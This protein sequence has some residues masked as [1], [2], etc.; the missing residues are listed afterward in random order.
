[1]KLKC[2]N[3]NALVSAIITLA[4]S[5]SMILVFFLVFG[6]FDLTINTYGFV[7]LIYAELFTFSFFILSCLVGVFGFVG[8]FSAVC[9][10][11]AK[12]VFYGNLICCFVFFGLTVSIIICIYFIK[13]AILLLNS[14][15][16]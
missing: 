1:M 12:W 11:F 16:T 15:E 14:C 6:G 10:K 5:A 8:I 2:N 9:T 4:I 13:D 7:S 3:W